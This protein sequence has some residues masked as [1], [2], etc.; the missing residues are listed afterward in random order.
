MEMAV[1]GRTR[2]EALE[3]LKELLWREVWSRELDIPGV[4]YEELGG[5]RVRASVDLRV[6]KR[7]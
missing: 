1:T 2:A 6:F 7:K 3:R 5:G 4:V